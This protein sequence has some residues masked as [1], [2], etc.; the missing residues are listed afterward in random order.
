MPLPFKWLPAAGPAQLET[1][2][3]QNSKFQ[4]E[5]ILSKERSSPEK[6]RIGVLCMEM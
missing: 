1:L 5:L 2:N 3:E 6:Q 4:E